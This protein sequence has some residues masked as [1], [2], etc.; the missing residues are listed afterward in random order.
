[1]AVRDINEKP[2]ILGGPKAVQ[3]NSSDLFAWPIVTAEDERAVLDVLR[4]RAMSGTDVAKEFEKEFATWQGRTYA[5]GCSSGTASLQAAMFGVKIGVGDEVIGPSI[6]HWASILPCLTLGA[7]PV[8]ADIDPVTLCID[9]GDIEHRITPRT[10]A[11]VVVHYFAHP[12]D[13]DAIMTIARKHNLAVIEDV[14]HAQGGFYKGRKVGTFGDVAAM[15]LMTEKSFAIGEA[16][17][18][19]TDNL[20]IYERAIALGHA[21]RLPEITTEYLQT[22][23]QARTP[24]GAYKH[25]MHQMSAA[26]GRVQLR[27]YDAR[28]R[29][30]DKAMKYFW[31]LLDGVPGLRPHH[32]TDVGST[33]AG[34][35]AARAHYLPNELG[36]LPVEEFAKAVKAEGAPC[37]PGVNVPLH[38]L[39]LTNDADILGHGKPTRIANS[40]R[41]VRQPAGSLPVS[42]RIHAVTCSIPWFKRFEPELILQHA[43]AFRKV[44]QHYAGSSH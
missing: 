36:G 39:P 40:V 27:A 14:S 10:K 16:G 21:T 5:L 44:A 41:D 42:E 4:R 38:L 20:E 22:F 35:Y 9:P 23:N 26:M 13:M 18:L 7:T 19:V 28:C 2:A 12:A 30:I 24:M 3:A 1:M 11:I 8:F 43:Q 37:S 25:R 34:W 33:M 29:E 15:S 17:I 6:T 32:P 31:E